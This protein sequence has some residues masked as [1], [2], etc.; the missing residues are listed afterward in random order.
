MEIKRNGLVMCAGCIYYIT[1]KII[2]QIQR[3][4]SSHLDDVRLNTVLIANLSCFRLPISIFTEMKLLTSFQGIRIGARGRGRKPAELNLQTATRRSKVDVM[5][6]VFLFLATK[7]GRWR[8]TKQRSARLLEDRESKKS[9][10]VG[11]LR[12]GSN[13]YCKFQKNSTV[14]PFSF[15]SLLPR[16]LQFFFSYEKR[17][18]KNICYG[19]REVLL[20]FYCLIF[21]MKS[22]N[23]INYWRWGFV[24]FREASIWNYC[25]PMR[26]FVYRMTCTS[27]TLSHET[28]QLHAL[29][30]LG[31]E[32]CFSECRGLCTEVLAKQVTPYPSTHRGGSKKWSFN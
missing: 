8:G 28:V 22:E 5:K 3:L 23:E 17:H 12:N 20:L 7:R 21:R 18:N 25:H 4:S 15:V 10:N 27:N 14:S 1:H 9:R 26:L 2:H 24:S 16:C 29:P 31:S 11:E 30:W 32:I 13:R 6:I 19:W